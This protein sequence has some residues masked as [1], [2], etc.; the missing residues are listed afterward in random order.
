[1][2]VSSSVPTFTILLPGKVAPSRHMVEPQSP[3]CMSTL[4]CLEEHTQHIPEVG[5]DLV[6][7][8]G[9]LLV[10][11]GG[12]LGDLELVCVIDTVGAV[13]AAT[14]LA[15]VGAVAENLFL[16]SATV[17][18]LGASSIRSLRTRLRPR[19]GRFRTCIL[20]RPYLLYEM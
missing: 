19:S 11:L 13:G 17:L 3:L 4:V 5:D 9:L 7:A 10:L 6:A 1:M 12:A 20:R 16:E 15:A 8:I 14:D 2:L 18:K